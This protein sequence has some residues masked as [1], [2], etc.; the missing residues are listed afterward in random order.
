MA[1]NGTITKGTKKESMNQGGKR[2]P[3]FHGDLDFTLDAVAD[4]VFKGAI[5]FLVSNLGVEDS[6]KMWSI[7]KE[8]ISNDVSG[9]GTENSDIYGP[10]LCIVYAFLLDRE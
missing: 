4:G 1:A 3:G 10:R 9:T 8:K 7:S 5:K 6:S 2:C